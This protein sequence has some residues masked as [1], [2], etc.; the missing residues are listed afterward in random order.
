MHFYNCENVKN[1][2]KFDDSQYYILSFVKISK[3]NSN[4]PVQVCLSNIRT[5]RFCYTGAIRSLNPVFQFQ[6]FFFK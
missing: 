5:T 1:S 2:Q 6:D 4:Q 3:T